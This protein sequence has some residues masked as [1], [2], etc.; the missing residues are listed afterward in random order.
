MSKLTPLNFQEFLLSNENIQKAWERDQMQNG[1]FDINA[2]WTKVQPNMA[3]VIKL[4][5]TIDDLVEAYNKLL[6]DIEAIKENQ[7]K[8]QETL[9]NLGKYLKD[10]EIL[11]LVYKKSKGK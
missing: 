9:E 6:D 4:T 10:E 3:L 8:M 11:K 1:N 2:F 7:V 5:D